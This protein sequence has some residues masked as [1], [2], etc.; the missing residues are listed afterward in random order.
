MLVYILFYLSDFLL[1]RLRESPQF[2]PLSAYGGGTCLDLRVCKIFVFIFPYSRRPIGFI[3][4]E[5]NTLHITSCFPKYGAP[6][7]MTNEGLWTKYFS[8]ILKTMYVLKIC[9]S[10]FKIN[11]YVFKW[12]YL[13][14]LIYLIYVLDFLCFLGMLFPTTLSCGST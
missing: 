13:I 6:W 8:K 9:Q 10:Y 11:L 5:P 3:L 1:L 7:A 12:I 2:W 4:C 14:Y